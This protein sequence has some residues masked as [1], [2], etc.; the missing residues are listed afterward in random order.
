MTTCPHCGG[1][2]ELSLNT[3]D[4]EEFWQAYPRKVGKGQAR[5]AYKLA[6][7][8]VGKTALLAGVKTFRQLALAKDKEFIPHPAT[9]LAGERW[10]DEGLTASDAG[11]IP[12]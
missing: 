12:A 1:K 2:F 4:F 9:W 6:H 7:A 8:K 10:T 5:K 3:D 11:S